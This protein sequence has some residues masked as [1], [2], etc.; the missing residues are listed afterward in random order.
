MQITGGTGRFK[1]LTG[2][3]TEDGAILPSVTPTG[4]DGPN[5]RVSGNL[6]MSFGAHPGG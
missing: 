3:I 5:G 2:T 1:G 6:V 4:F